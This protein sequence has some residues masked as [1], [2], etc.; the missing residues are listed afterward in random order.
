MP[1]SGHQEVLWLQ[2]AVGNFLSVQIFKSEHDFG[3]VKQRDVVGEQILASQ[4]SENLTALHVFERKVNV[5]VILETLMPV[6]GYALSVTYR[7]T[8]KGKKIW[9]SRLFSSLMW[10]TCLSSIIC[11]FFSAF[12]A[13]GCPLIKAR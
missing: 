12:N 10:S 6:P 13:T 4:K 9:A 11:V 5:S 7:F 1:I 8:M 3:N 2:V